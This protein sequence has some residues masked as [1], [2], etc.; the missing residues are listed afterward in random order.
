VCGAPLVRSS[1][2]SARFLMLP[3]RERNLV[4]VGAAL[5]PSPY[6]RGSLFPIPRATRYEC[7][8]M[9]RMTSVPVVSE[10]TAFGCL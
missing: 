7:H 4:V 6:R 2:Y 8:S 10:I 3:R 5:G 9:T 1:L